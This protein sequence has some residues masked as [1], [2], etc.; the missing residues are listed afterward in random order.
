MKDRYDVT[1]TESQR[2]TLSLYHLRPT[3][4]DLT[5]ELGAYTLGDKEGEAIIPATFKPCPT[6]ACRRA[7]QVKH[8]SKGVDCGGGKPHRLAANVETVTMLGVDLDHLSSDVLLMILTDLRA[9]GLRFWWWNTHSHCPP[10]DA[11]ARLL[12]PFAEPFTVRRAK[13][14]SKV[15]WPAL[16]RELGLE[17]AAAAD[18]QCSDPCRVYYLPRKPSA[19]SPHAAGFEN[20]THE[21]DWRN[22]IKPEEFSRP[23]LTPQQPPKVD[24]SQPVDLEKIRARLKAIK[25]DS[26]VLWARVLSGEAPTP[27]P[28]ERPPGEP[29]RYGAWRTLTSSIA[30]VADEHEPSEALLTILEPAWLTECAESPEDHT[31]WETIES[32]LEQARARA[33]EWKADREATRAQARATMMSALAKL[34]V[35]SDG[36]VDTPAPEPEAAEPLEDEAPEGED[37]R[38]QVEQDNDGNPKG[39]LQNLC[40]F[41]RELPEWR[42]HLRLNTLTKSIEVHGGPLL[43]P[44][45]SPGRELRDSDA[46]HAAAWFA[47]HTGS[48]VNEG[49]MWGVLIAVGEENAYNP[50]TD[51]L[52]ACFTAWDGISRAPDWLVTYLGAIDPGGEYLAAVGTRWLVGAVMRAYEPGCKFDTMLTVEGDQGVG[53]ST[54]LRVLGGQWFTDAAISMADQKAA[55]EIISEN[56]IV[57][58]AE[59]DGLRKGEVTAQRAFLSR[60][61]DDFRPAYGRRRVR[62]PRC[63]VFVGTSN[64]DD[65]LTDEAGNRRHWPVSVRQVDLEALR[66]DRDQLWGEAV[67]LYRSGEVTP[68][69]DPSEVPEQVLQT[70]HRE[71]SDPIAESVQYWLLKQQ[72]EKRPQYLTVRQ[73]LVDVLEQPDAS[74]GSAARVA[75]ALRRIGCTK[76]PLLG[77]ARV[78][79]YEVAEH[80]L[81]APQQVIGARGPLGVV[82]TPHSEGDSPPHT[83]PTHTGTPSK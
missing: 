63:C 51:Y 37:W 29:S 18:A 72:P 5:T 47:L 20:G 34:R 75:A 39:S 26:R 1:V 52:D 74:K 36:T 50:L 70:Q 10:S 77:P 61:F 66:R 11:R 3:V 83:T 43:R 64:S 22:Y 57:E 41:L 53:K 23:L 65:Y 78:R 21:L 16:I 49:R 60:T 27:P 40:V 6:D 82:R 69:L 33:D 19:D 48:K 54:A 24:P 58:V 71:A 62:Y 80:L 46:I 9:R 45:D 4:L 32:L 76:G 12:I 59:M 73:V 2:A 28:D 31:E 55:A 35:R 56:W 44:G 15:L 79:S 8:D 42:G 38:R 7:K 30:A 68:Y 25:G 14:W 17:G 67:A 13:D 81:T